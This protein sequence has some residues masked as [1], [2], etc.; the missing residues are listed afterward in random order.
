MAQVVNQTRGGKCCIMVEDAPDNNSSN[1]KFSRRAAS[2][3]KQS[4]TWLLPNPSSEVPFRNGNAIS[5]L[6]LMQER[7]CVQCVDHFWEL[8]CLSIFVVVHL[9]VSLTAPNQE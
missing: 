1:V 5:T 3:N 2:C 4:V 6:S 8:H 7:C 9:T